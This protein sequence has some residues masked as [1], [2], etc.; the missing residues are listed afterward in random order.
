MKYINTKQKII[1]LLCFVLI[2]ITIFAITEINKKQR[3]NLAVNTNIKDLQTQFDVINRFHKIDAQAI[4]FSTQNNPKVQEILLQLEN[5]DKKK[6]NLLRIELYNQ[7]KQNYEYMKLKGVLQYHFVMPDN[8]TFLRMHKPEKYD[9]DLGVIRYS[10]AN[11]NKTHESTLGFEQGKTAHAFR[12]T[13]PVFDRDSNYLCALD[14]GYGSEVIQNH[15]TQVNQLHTHFLVHKDIFSVKTWERKWLKLNYV[16]SIEHADYMFAITKEHTPARLKRTK[17]FLTESHKRKIKENINL[18]KSFGIYF[19]QDKKAIVTSFI[20]ISNIKDKKVVAY[21]VSYKPNSFIDTTLLLIKTVRLAMFLLF[22]VLFYFIYKNV[23]AARK[24]KEFNIEL[25]RKVKKRTYELEIQ[26]HRAEEAHDKIDIR[27]KELNEALSKVKL[28]SGFIP[29]CASC[30]SIRDDNGYWNQIESY[31][32]EHSMAEFSHSICP[33]CA[34]KLY[35]E[36]YAKMENS[37]K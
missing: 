29:I 37:E 32:K 31:I 34:K 24:E 7:L 26:K 20:P 30:K 19:L 5:V 14:I 33:E 27:N 12:N 1:L 35:P 25:E 18:G 8:T 17:R 15:L 6:K 11:T 22:S 9:D 4:Y 16:Q 3:I 23:L 21:L 10:F 28:L 13:Y 36:F 2:N